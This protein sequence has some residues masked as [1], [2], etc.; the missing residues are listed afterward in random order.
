LTTAGRICYN[1]YNMTKTRKKG[2]P[3][4]GTPSPLRGRPSPIRGRQFPHL[5]ASGPDPDHHA[6]WR[7][8]LVAR[9]QARYWHQEWTVSWETY[10]D[11]L[12]PHI[13]NL[14]RKKDAWNLVRRD[15]TGTWNDSNV[16][17]SQRIS[18]I[19]ANKSPRPYLPPHERER[20]R[21]NMEQYKLKG[22][23]GK[24]YKRYDNND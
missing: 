22:Y 5:W 14:G 4:K 6:L 20:R 15:R 16:M 1:K 24:R 13:N 17:A 12:L 21:V 8:F 2:G 23:T 18:M 10:R 3:K 9:N 7:R 19:T 11:L